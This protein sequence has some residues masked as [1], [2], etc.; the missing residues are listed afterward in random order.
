MPLPALLI[1]TAHAQLGAAV[2]KSLGVAPLE[3]TIA[4]FADGET[5]IDIH[6]EVRA[7]DVYIIAPTCPPVNEN[8]MELMLLAD[9]AR[10]ASATRI[11]ALVPYFGY[12]RQDRRA[13]AGSPISAKVVADMLSHVGIHRVVTVDLHSPQTQGF[14]DCLHDNLHAAPLFANMLRDTF[15]VLDLVMV[16]PDV[17]GVVRARSLAR[18]VGVP[19]AILDKRRDEKTGNVA[20]MNLIGEVRGK[21][22][23][24][25][26]DMIDTAGTLTAAAHALQQAG[27][28]RVVAVA[29]HGLFSGT[30]M[31][32]LAASPLTDIWVSD[33]VPAAAD[34]TSG[35][36][37]LHRLTLAPLLAK[38][39]TALH[40]GDSLVSL[41]HEET[42]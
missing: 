16:S 39:I 42:V 14:F 34:I 24:L 20:G 15:N 38:T 29:T 30:A 6:G 28:T 11:T 23:V 1:G 40:Q 31:E 5:H 8:I 9:A 4:K 26:D 10:R 25:V 19:L 17:G 33:S 41:Y 27:A 32:R 3:C 37:R 7:R 18:R 21:T 13:T 22:A 2:A 35:T 12:A 36:V